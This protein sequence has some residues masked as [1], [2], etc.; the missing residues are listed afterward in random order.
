TVLECRRNQLQVLSRGLTLGSPWQNHLRAET[1]FRPLVR[2][3][4]CR[5]IGLKALE[6]TSLRGWVLSGR[7]QC[8]GTETDNS[9]SDQHCRDQACSDFGVEF[10]HKLRR[11]Q[12]M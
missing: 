3:K 4:Q 12:A 2:I 5:F 6:G 9:H 8:K 10:L 1:S 11:L 7:M